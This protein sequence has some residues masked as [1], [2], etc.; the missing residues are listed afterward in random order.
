VN[1]E[2][3]YQT[4]FAATLACIALSACRTAPLYEPTRRALIAAEEDEE[5]TTVGHSVSGT[6][7]AQLRTGM[8]YADALTPCCIY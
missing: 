4:V 2:M 1:I 6:A 7:I 3:K 5:R 8:T